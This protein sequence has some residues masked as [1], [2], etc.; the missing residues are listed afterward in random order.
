MSIADLNGLMCLPN[1]IYA[2]ERGGVV[3]RPDGTHFVGQGA[4]VV[5]RMLAPQ[6]GLGNG[7]RS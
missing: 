1:G 6:M 5:T 2:T 4:Q 3:L 7:G